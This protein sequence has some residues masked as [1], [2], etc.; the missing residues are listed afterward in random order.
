MFN[1][2]TEYA[3]RSLVYIQHQN[4]QNLRPGIEEIAKEIEA[5]QAFTAKILQR[6]VRLG[7]VNSIK[8]KGGGFHF[9]ESKSE[10]SLKQLILSIEG[11]KIL[12]G[13]GFGM[14]HCDANHP[15]PL[16]DQYGPIREAINKLVSEETI[17]SLA[18]KTN[19][20]FKVLNF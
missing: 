1:K 7:F 3:L 2:E 17:Q 14:K 11:G 16:H 10:L 20:A 19:Q 6:M 4:Y 12:D 5:P 13:C 15:C 9:D 18:Q 8:G